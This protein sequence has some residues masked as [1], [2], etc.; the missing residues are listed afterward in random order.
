M[1]GFRMSFDR[2]GGAPEHLLKEN[3]H[4][5]VSIPIPTEWQII[6][7]LS[8]LFDLS[9]SKKITQVRD[10]NQNLSQ[11]LATLDALLDKKRELQNVKK[12]NKN[13]LNSL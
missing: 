2:L 1:E 5:I 11:S 8:Y 7:L 13:I 3:Q 9:V 12:K 10:L 6:D 4:P